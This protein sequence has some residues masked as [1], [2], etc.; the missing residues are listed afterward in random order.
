MACKKRLGLVGVGGGASRHTVVSGGQGSLEGLQ[1]LPAD[2]SRDV[3]TDTDPEIFWLAGFEPPE[4]F[5]VALRRIDEYGDTH[6]V[7]TELTKTAANRWKL[8]VVGSL[9]E[10]A[11]YSI[12]VRDDT[13]GTHREAWFLTEKSR[14]RTHKP[15]G[16]QPRQRGAFEH[17]VVR[18][19]RLLP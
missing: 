15:S 8:K 7:S 17:T 12:I 16:E 18:G 2:H 14:F 13:R 5:T 11:L 19:E 10:G 1:F 4:R 9:E 3:D 6:P